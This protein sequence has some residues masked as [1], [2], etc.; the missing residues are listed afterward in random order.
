MNYSTLDL[1]DFPDCEIVHDNEF[2]TLITRLAA[3]ALKEICISTFKMEYPIR[4]CLVLKRFFDT[5]VDKSKA[6]LQV[7]ILFNWHPSL[8]SVPRSNYPTAR[9]LKDNGIDLR[10][11]PNNRCC[12]TKLFLSDK[13]NMV[14]GSHNLSV[15]SVT[16]NFD[17]SLFL[18]HPSLVL[19][20]H[21]AFW[22]AFSSSKKF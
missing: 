17:I 14:I 2:I 21:A 4:K 6:G 15:A 18:R 3:Y 22:A 20:A 5:L 7:H 8:F 13:K 11:L 1:M 12:H 16:S 10:Y 19:D 9:Y